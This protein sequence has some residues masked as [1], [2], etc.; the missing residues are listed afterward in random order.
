MGEVGTSKPRGVG[1]KGCTI[2]FIGCG[3]SKSYAPGPDDEEEEHQTQALTYM[4]VIH[5]CLKSWI[6][7][8]HSND[9][10]HSIVKILN[11]LCI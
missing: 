6:F 4:N 7:S 11:I 1:D 9:D 5:Y 10:I 8:F 3:A 2:S